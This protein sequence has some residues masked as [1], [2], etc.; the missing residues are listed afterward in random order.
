MIKKGQLASNILI[1][2]LGFVIGSFI[3]IYGYR[4]IYSLIDNTDQAM[5]L[6]LENSL[7]RNIQEVSR[8]PNTVR[9][10]DISNLPGRYNT[11]C[12]LDYS[13]P[14][15]EDDFDNY[16]NIIC[17]AH[18]DKTSN[19]ILLPF[20]SAY[21]N[22]PEIRLDSNPLCVSTTGTT[23]KIIGQGRSSLIQVSE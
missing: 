22:I 9:L 15:N 10:F 18:K 13:L 6:R 1:Y 7:T 11:I 3:L 12:F 20:E 2:A 8:L 4:T 17:N 23:L 16:G 14:C 21:I 19:V 5:L